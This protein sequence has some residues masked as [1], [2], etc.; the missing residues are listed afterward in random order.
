MCDRFTLMQ[1]EMEFASRF[2]KGVV[3]TRIKPRYNI[4]PSQ[5]VAVLVV[6]KNRLVEKEMRWGWTPVWSKQLLINAQCET[7]N[8]KPTL[9]RAFAERRC[10]IPADGFYEWQTVGGKKSPVRFVLK[11]GEPFCF[12][13]LWEPCMKVSAPD[14]L[15]VNDFPDEPAASQV[16]ESVLILTTAAND[17]VRPVHERMPVILQPAHYDWWLEGGALAG[18][19]MTHPRNGELEWYRVSPLVNNARVDDVKCIARAEQPRRI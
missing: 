11:S 9:K 3:R 5:Q 8:V 1:E 6:D 14:D 10:L 17:I 13:G 18:M 15:P 4:A 19:A 2:A 7:V 12:A 16:V